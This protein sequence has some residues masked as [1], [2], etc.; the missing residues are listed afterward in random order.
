MKIPV[1]LNN[2]S[3]DIILAKAALDQVDQEVN[4]Q[5]KVLLITD[6]GVP[7]EYI[8]KLLNKCRKPILAI[9]PQG[10]A[11]KSFSQYK[12]LLQTL[13]NH[14]FTRTDLI[15]A[16]GGGMVGDLAGFVAATYMRGIDFINIPTTLLAQL[17]SSLG[18]K[19]AINFKNIKNIVGSFHQPKKVIIDPEVL[20][21]LSPRQMNAGLAEAIKM[22]TTSDANL[23]S[24]IANQNAYDNL[25]EIIKLSLQ[26]KSAIIEEDVNETGLRKVLNFGHTV[27]HA[28][29][30]QSSLLHGESIAIGMLYFCSEQVRL[31]LQNVFKKY[32]LP[33]VSD[34]SSKDIYQAIIHDKKVSGDKI[35]IVYVA[36]IG[37]FVFK[38]LP[39]IDLKKIIENKF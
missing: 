21:T 38:T 19:T 27:G 16:V 36:S 22:A 2:N 11:S 1:N 39:L 23:F 3:Y 20:H 7:K 33:I 34:L 31:Q 24:L 29:E 17:D 30:S 6:D 14:E 13:I 5:G 18:G 37:S 28:I 15:I 32:K 4:L 8:N 35:T 9:I 12:S 26:I 25:E 10:E